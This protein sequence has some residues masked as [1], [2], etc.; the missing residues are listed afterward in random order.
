MF[1]YRKNTK[2]HVSRGLITFVGITLLITQMNRILLTQVQE[3]ISSFGLEYTLMS[4]FRTLEMWM[5]G[6]RAYCLLPIIKY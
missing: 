3:I 6:I 4:D 1:S 5:Y 2:T